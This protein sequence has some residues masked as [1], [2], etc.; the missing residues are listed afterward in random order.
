MNDTN[1]LRSALEE[2]RA[3]LADPKAWTQCKSSRGVNGAWC[4]SSSRDAVQW[5]LLGAAVRCA[6][7][8]VGVYDEIVES[9]SLTINPQ[10]QQPYYSGGRI[11]NWNDAPERRHEEVLALIDLAISNST[12]KKEDSP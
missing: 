11:V 12:Q 5:C 9:L 1:H 4:D 6:H 2:M 10:A 7:M 3:L 8:V